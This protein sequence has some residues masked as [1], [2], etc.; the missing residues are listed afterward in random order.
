MHEESGCVSSQFVHLTTYFCEDVSSG[1][2]CAHLE[3]E[4][5]VLKFSARVILST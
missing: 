4:S 1:N 2:C 3:Q 5:Q